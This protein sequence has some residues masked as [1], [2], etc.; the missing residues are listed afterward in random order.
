[1]H[2][3]AQ[4]WF[5]PFNAQTNLLKNAFRSGIENGVRRARAGPV[6]DLERL[7]ASRLALDTLVP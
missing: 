5:P 6:P 4:T 2:T 7:P 1:V 3:L